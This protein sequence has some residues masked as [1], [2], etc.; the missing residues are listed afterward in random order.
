MTNTPRDQLFVDVV[1]VGAGPSGLATAIRL[2]QK[3]PS[4][5]ILVLEKGAEVGAHIVSGAMVDPTPLDALLPGWRDE[6]GTPF[7]TRVREDRFTLVTPGKIDSM[8]GWLLP[9]MLKN[10]GSYIVSLGE[11][12]R[13]L[14]GKAEA[15]GIDIYS[16]FSAQSLL[17]ERSGRVSGVSTGDMGLL[18]DGAPGPSFQAG[19]DIRARYTVL[20]EGARGSL[21]KQAIRRFRLSNGR[22]PQKFGLGIKE[23]WEIDPSRH[24]PGRVEHGIGWPLGWRTGG[25]Y[26]L[27][28]LDEPRVVLGLV[29]HLDYEDPSLSPFGELQR[30]KQHPALQALLRG[31]RRIGYGARVIAEGGWQSVPRLVFPGG[32]LVGDTAGFV[33]IARIKGTHN[34]LWSG[35]LAADYISRAFL[36]GDDSLAELDTDWRA[37]EIGGDLYPARNIKPLWS[38]FGL[39]GLALGGLDLWTQQVLKWSAFGTMAH[40][41]S[42]HAALRPNAAGPPRV[43]PRPDGQFTFD[44]LSS[45]FLANTAHRDDQPLHLKVADPNLQERSEL[46]IY[47]GPSQH[48]CPA[49]V[50]EWLYDAKGPRLRIN[51]QNCI[52][53]KTCDVKDPC[54]NIDW[55]PPEGGSGPNYSAM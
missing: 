27:Y 13:W 55:V 17:T 49:G 39:F 48:Y 3:Q 1:V 11:V 47:G 2:K 22:G 5:S 52:H 6:M 9:R 18:P 16:G 40:R 30:F 45:V 23:V 34:A 10:S 12:C 29:V 36:T 42:D 21:G 28:H 50:Y 38:R 19:V 51:A 20:A 32:V 41:S 31:G 37:S 25:G 43:Y 35:V 15:L 54:Q 14:A 7:R 46:G 53:C 4:L 44:R 8:P 33:N 24:R 26:F